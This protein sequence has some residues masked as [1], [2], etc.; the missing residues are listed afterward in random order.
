MQWRCN[1]CGAGGEVVWKSFLQGERRV[2]NR[3]GAWTLKK[4]NKASEF[5]A[6]FE[7]QNQTFG[8]ERACVV[9]LV[10]AELV[11]VGSKSTGLLLK[12]DSTVSK[13][14]CDMHD[15]SPVDA[16][17]NQSWFCSWYGLFFFLALVDVIDFS[18]ANVVSSSVVSFFMVLWRDELNSFLHLWWIVRFLR[19]PLRYINAVFDSTIVSQSCSPTLYI[20][21]ANFDVFQASHLFSLSQHL[22]MKCCSRFCCCS[23]LFASGPQPCCVTMDFILLP[24]LARFTMCCIGNSPVMRDFYSSV[25]S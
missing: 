13:E 2:P 3:A 14:F 22:R 1:R 12:N 9:G 18:L 23:T 17:S 24:A 10:D 25:L 20:F 19:F 21:G 15:S 16:A 5:H 7:R 11:H 4:L 8:A 6:H